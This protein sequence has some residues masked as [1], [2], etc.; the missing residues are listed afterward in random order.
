MAGMKRVHAPP[1]IGCK[2]QPSIPN[3]RCI[4]MHKLQTHI[5]EGIPRNEKT[6]YLCVVPLKSYTFQQVG[7]DQQWNRMQTTSAEATMTNSNTQHDACG[8]L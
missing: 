7:G 2:R 5:N 4:H 1:L 6:S 8:Q 3:L